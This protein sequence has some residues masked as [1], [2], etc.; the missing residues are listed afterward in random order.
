MKK[1]ATVFLALILIALVTAAFTPLTA[2]TI[3]PR[4]DLNADNKINNRDLGILQRYIN[5]W[6]VEIP[7]LEP[8]QGP[9][10]EPGLSAYEIAVKNGYSGSESEWLASLSDSTELNAARYGI[11]PGVVDES[12][13]TA[14]LQ[15]A[16]AQNKTI[17]FNDGVYI[18]SS[19]MNV[20]SNTSI[21]GS[22]NTIFQ[23]APDASADTLIRISAGADNVFL[24]HL[25]LQGGNAEAPTTAGK[26]T[27]L[28]ISGTAAIN[29]ENIEISGFDLYGLYATS[30]ASTS[31][32]KFYKM[33]QITNCRFY[34]NYYGMCLGPRCEYTQTLNCVFG[35]NY[36]GCLN[37]GGNNSYASCIFNVNHIGFQMDSAGLSNPAH[38]GC[39]AC[40]FNHNDYPIVVNDCSIGWIFNGC[41]VFY[42]TIRLNE[43]VGVVFDSSIFGSCTLNSKHSTKSNVNLI[44]NSYF[45]TDSNK[46]LR[47]N[48]GS[49][50]ISN[51]LPDHLD[52]LEEEITNLI[53][54]D[55]WTQLLHTVDGN[56]PGASNCYFANCS[57]PIA[58]QE[59]KAHLYIAIEGAKKDSIVN[60]VNVWVVDASTN[61]VI[62]QVVDDQSLMVSYSN[63]LEKYV[64]HIELNE[65]YDYPIYFVAQAIRE[66]SIGISYTY[67]SGTTQFLDTTEVTIGQTIEANSSIIAEFAVFQES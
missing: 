53:A 51:C 45:Q 59:G 50:Y 19:T 41:Q 7:E 9:Q 38:G 8:I 36:I 43:S 6:D 30:T 37:Q 56:R 55:N 33:L 58:L 39:N 16:S 12:S 10:G 65:K 23:L 48:D 46:I 64:L 26:R 18:F 27:G 28:S 21:V 17:R 2:A 66:N 32:G 15:Q 24:S 31:T 47:E 61:T 29:L 3:N 67:T 4:G 14:L 63:A 35:N 40:T 25:N 1:I 57:S 5:D 34:N 54:D 49:T 42:G 13:M 62:E 52:N 11:V 20:L 60:G 44:S 22:T